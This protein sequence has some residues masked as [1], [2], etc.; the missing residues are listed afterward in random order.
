MG[1]VKQAYMS[2]MESISSE[3]RQRGMLQDSILD[4]ECAFQNL[5]YVARLSVAKV[6]FELL[7]DAMIERDKNPD[8]HDAA[9]YV[10]GLCLALSY[11]LNAEQS[12][13]AEVAEQLELMDYS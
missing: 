11:I 3:L 4:L 5:D 6:A 12:E 10:G 8:D 2:G 9:L 13:N 1:A 7:D